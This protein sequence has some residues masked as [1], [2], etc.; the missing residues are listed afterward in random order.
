MILT[1]TVSRN[2]QYVARKT[3]VYYLEKRR[4]AAVHARRRIPSHEP[5]GGVAMKTPV[6]IL[7]TFG[8][9]GRAGRLQ[10]RA[11]ERGRA[12]PTYQEAATAPLL[13]NS[14]EAVSKLTA[15][16]DLNALGGGPVLVATV[17]NVNDLGPL[18]PA[19]AAPVGQYASQMAALGFNVKS[20]AA[21]RHLRQGR[22]GR[23]AAVA[24]DQGHR[25]QLQR[26]AGAR[27]HL[28]ACRQLHLREPE[29]GAHRRQP[30]HP[31]PRLRTAQRPRRA[32]PVGRPLTRHRIAPRLPR[33]F[34]SHPG[35]VPHA[36]R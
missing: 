20:Q 17:V 33:Q 15:G 16:F 13:Q 1:T 3:D 25:A 27:G 23:A 14:R 36:W 6:A 8:R 19:G 28:L 12:E 29:A 18:G 35:W 26:L 5:E 9:R 31:R 22:C 24:R 11:T 10:Q 34:F 4:H 7:S 21:R 32:A 2:G 30:H